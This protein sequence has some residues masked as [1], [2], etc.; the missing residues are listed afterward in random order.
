MT[1]A[2]DSTGPQDDGSHAGVGED[3]ARAGGGRTES[4]TR[5]DEDLGSTEHE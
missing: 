4:E 3:P 2:T 1:E 5:V